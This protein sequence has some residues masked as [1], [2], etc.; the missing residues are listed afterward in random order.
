MTARKHERGI[1]LVIVLWIGLLVVAI[2][3]AFIVDTRNSTRMTRN[4]LDNAE[5][6]ALADGGVHLAVHELLRSDETMQWQRDGRRYKRTVP[7]GTLE[8]A[9]EDEA[10]KIDLNNATDDLLSGLFWTAGIDRSSADEL[11]K[12]VHDVRAGKERRNQSSRAARGSTSTIDEILSSGRNSSSRS[13]SRAANRAFQSVDSLGQV[14][15]MTPALYAKLRPALTVFGDRRLYY[16][17]SPREALLAIPGITEEAVDTFLAERSTEDEIGSL[18]EF[19]AKGQARNF[20]R[21]G[22]SKYVM[23][24]VLAESR[25]GAKFVRTAIVELLGRGD[26][27]FKVKEWREGDTQSIWPQIQIP[28]APVRVKGG[29]T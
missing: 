4:F 21:R 1:A 10:G 26:I 27:P 18:N 3:G 22:K 11:A 6:R 2:A 15:G 9:I 12:A 28:S 13:R 17:T 14:P 23:V 19:V 8:I 7:G 25:S 5:A 29:A 16:Q 24:K 20:W